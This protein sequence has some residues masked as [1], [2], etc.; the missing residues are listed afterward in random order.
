MPPANPAAMTV[1]KSDAPILCA[2]MAEQ[3]T[4]AGSDS[5]C[6]SEEAA[7]IS[8]NAALAYLAAMPKQVPL[9]AVFA[10][11]H[12][13]ACGVGADISIP[14]ISLQSMALF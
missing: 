7:F 10:R 6:I 1:C 12:M 13:I 8:L 3:L 9:A 11:N 14:V 2:S 4:G 5:I